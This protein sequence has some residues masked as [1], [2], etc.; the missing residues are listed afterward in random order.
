[1]TN[2]HIENF[3][4]F[5]SSQMDGDAVPPA[6]SAE[7]NQLSMALAELQKHQSG[8]EMQ[9]LALRTIGA[10]IDRVRSN[11]TAE[12]ALREFIQPGSRS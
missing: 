10:V 2:P 9:L 12:K 8:Q 3:I 5:L 11:I 1:M 6:G 4:S 7:L